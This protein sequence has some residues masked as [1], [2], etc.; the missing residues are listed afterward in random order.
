LLAAATL[1]RYLEDYEPMPNWW[2]IC[3]SVDTLFLVGER[4]AIAALQTEAA[5]PVGN[6]SR[7]LPDIRMSVGPCPSHERNR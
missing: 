2:G 5:D 4:P 6:Q 3:V 7:V 1:L